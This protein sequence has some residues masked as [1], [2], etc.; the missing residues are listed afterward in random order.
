MPEAGD[1]T[2][3]LKMQTHIFP[4][5]SPCITIQSFHPVFFIQKAWLAIIQ[6]DFCAPKVVRL[7]RLHCNIFGII[8]DKWL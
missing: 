2:I 6:P 8:K 4:V 1:E 5:E 7:T 3:S